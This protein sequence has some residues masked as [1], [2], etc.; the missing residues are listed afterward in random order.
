MARE[1]LVAGLSCGEVLAELSEY[2]DGTLDPARAGQ[3]EAHLRGCDWCERFGGR[4]AAS[5]AALRRHLGAPAPPDPAVRARLRERLA[6][7][8]VS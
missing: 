2:I 4:Y 1:R 7:E 8:G 6:R 5:V 3:I